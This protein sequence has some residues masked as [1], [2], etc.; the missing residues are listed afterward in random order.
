[1]KL[2]R[3]HR[4]PVLHRSACAAFCLAASAPALAAQ[5]RRDTTAADSARRIE[6]LVIKAGRTPAAVGG[7][8]AVVVRPDSLRTSPAPLLEEVLR[9]TPFVL[10]RQNSRGEMELSVR[11]S[12]SRQ[13]AVFV[14]GVPLTLGW[15]HRSDPSLIPLSG[16]QSLVLV[17]GLSSLLQGPNV[18]GG[19]IDLGIGRSAAGDAPRRQLWAGTGVDQYGGRALSVGGVM[20]T[21]TSSAGT[22]TLRAGGGYRERDGFR[23]TDAARDSTADDDLR[24]NSDLRQYDGF[25]TLRWQGGS[26]R[27]LGVTATGYSAERGVPP[28]LHI[29]EPRL[30]RYPEQSRVLASV[31]AGT[32]A[33]ATP[34]GTGSLDVTGGYNAGRLEIESFSD[35]RYTTLDARELGDE[36]TATGRVTA[37][38]SLPAGGELHAAF[39]GGD[40]RY[41]ENLDDVV[42]DYRQRLWSTGVEAEVPIF[43]RAL[44]GGGLVYDAATTPETGGKESLGRVDAWGWRGGT[45]V[46]AS[47]ALRLHASVS[48]RSRFPALRELYS[49]ALNRFRP[50]PN[51][52][53]ERLTGAELGATFG[54]DA[55]ASFGGLSFQAVG[56][57]HRLNDAVVRTT[58]PDTRLFVRVN[59][60]EIRSTGAELLGAWRS[61]VDPARA[62]VLTGDL[63]AQRVRVQDDSA[64]AERRPEH[65]PEVRGSLELGVPLPALVRAFAGVRYTG[66]QYCVHPDAGN[67]VRLGG[68]TEGNAAVERNWSLGR[69]TAAF[70]ALRTILA[71]DNLTDATVYD[72]CGLPQPGRTLRLVVQLR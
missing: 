32:G 68:Q 34:L 35:R 70:G 44:I 2:G 55:A 7:T 60:D 71:L 37:R 40:V 14:D 69:G 17:R 20:P 46:L 13:A 21:V 16:V 50:N 45:T 61:S 30:W 48:R 29:A 51:L 62:I 42:S 1:M 28:E 33:I 27:Y 11:G 23:V 67:Q 41:E 47:D 56:F 19:V 24:T 52:K 53:P 5:E 63:L 38:H 54:D 8:G 12:D 22:L 4:L 31:S 39:T 59:R 26:G 6:R 72:Q 25:A 15:D 10:V 64:N 65:Q 3:T 18:L 66:T 36:R 49:G 9:E 58:V 43:S 57:H